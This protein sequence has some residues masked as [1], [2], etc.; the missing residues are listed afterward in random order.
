MEE[1]KTN[2]TEAH[3]VPFTV[4]FED[5]GESEITRTYRFTK[6]TK[7]KIQRCQKDMVKSPDRAYRALVIDCVHPDDRADLRAD[8]EE[9]PGLPATFGNEILRRSGFDSLGK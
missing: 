8:I 6:P 1:T 2:P 4:E 9:Y 3:Y 5:F 7:P